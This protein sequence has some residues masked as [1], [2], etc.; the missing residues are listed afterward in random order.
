MSERTRTLV[1]L[2][3]VANPVTLH[4]LGTLHEAFGDRFPLTPGLEA[5][6]AAGRRVV[7]EPDGSGRERDVDP[8]I[9]DAFGAPGGDGALDGPGV[10]DAVLAGLTQEVGLLLDEGVVSAPQDV[11][12]CMI[13]GAGFPFHLGGLVPL[14]DRT[15]WTERVL[16]HRLLPAGVASIG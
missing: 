11:D 12:L 13:L 4:V 10:L 8:A 9:Q 3:L 7:P 2:I 15:G 5:L 6:S 1:D 14:L 16:G